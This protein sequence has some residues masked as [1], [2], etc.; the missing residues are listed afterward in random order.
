MCVCVCVCVCALLSIAGT[1]W[2]SIAPG[3]GEGQAH[4]HAW[5]AMS[6]GVARGAHRW[7]LVGAVGT[8]GLSATVNGERKRSAESHQLHESPD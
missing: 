8:Q 4:K 2:Q 7:Q 6:E 3:P 1:T 5:W